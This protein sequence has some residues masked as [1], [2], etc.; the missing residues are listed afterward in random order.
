MMINKLIEKDDIPGNWYTPRK[1]ETVPDRPP[2]PPP[3]V[4]RDEQG[5]GVEDD[6]GSLEKLGTS[7][8]ETPPADEEIRAM[9][10]QH[11]RPGSLS[12][13]VRGEGIVSGCKA[14]GHAWPF[15]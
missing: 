15:P 10:P 8:G 6:A 5:W 14:N 12:S 7:P 1:V 13:A 9:R 11:R 2:P 4:K 3:Q